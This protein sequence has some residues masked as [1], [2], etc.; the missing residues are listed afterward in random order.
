MSSMLQLGNYRSLIV[1]EEGES[2]FVCGFD[3]WSVNLALVEGPAYMSMWAA[4]GGLSG[5]FFFFS[6]AHQVGDLCGM[7]ER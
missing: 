3:Y 2:T 4:Q 1:S 5:L 6:E 7:L